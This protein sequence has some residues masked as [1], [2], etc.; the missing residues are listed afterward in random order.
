MDPAGRVGSG[1]VWSGL[2]N[3]YTIHMHIHNYVPTLVLSCQSK[4]KV[5]FV[6]NVC[7]VCRSDTSRVFVTASSIQLV[8]VL[9]SGT[10]HIP[11][12]R[13]GIQIC[14]YSIIIP[15]LLT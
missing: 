4:S 7:T 9:C 3:M 6:R 14:I 13:G 10:Y 1:L 15:Y 12:G 11:L 5:P 8:L 2:G